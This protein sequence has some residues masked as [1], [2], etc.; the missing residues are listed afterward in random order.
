[1]VLER[2]RRLDFL[3]HIVNRILAESGASRQLVD[4]IRRM[5]GRAEDKYKFNA[6][7]GNVERLADY[8]RSRD[9]DD[10]VT[11]VRADRSGQGI[12]L[13]KRILEEAKKAYSDVPGVVEAI[14]A[15]LS[16]LESHETSK[17]KNKAATLYTVLKDLEK[18]KAKVE[19]D[20]ERNEVQVTALDGKFTA[21]VSYDEKSNAFTLVYRAEGTVEL[22]SPSE[23]QEY[24][25]KMLST[26]QG[27]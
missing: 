16:E 14:E 20:E 18:L 11:L 15:R 13:L 8:L 10:L 3:R 1:M 9:F 5:V 23:V 26:L 22:S 2:P 25:K 6:F 27:K 24:L 17:T 4:D 19:F 7:G 21:T 12:E